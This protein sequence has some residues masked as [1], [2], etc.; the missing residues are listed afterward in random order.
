M[1]L[2]ALQDLGDLNIANDQ[3]LAEVITDRWIHY[4]FQ[5]DDDIYAR[6]IDRSGTNLSTNT[7]T[8]RIIAGGDIFVAGCAT[9][10]S[11]GL[12]LASTSHLSRVGQVG[13]NPGGGHDPDDWRPGDGL[14]AV[15]QC[16]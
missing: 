14:A 8:S 13:R 2:G 4:F 9:D 3:D 10:G 7:P 16:L 11:P 1:T 12:L 5:T 15:D 6:T